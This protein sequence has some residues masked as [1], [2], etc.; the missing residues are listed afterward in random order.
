MSELTVSAGWLYTKATRLRSNEDVNLFPPGERVV[1]IRDTARNI[2]GLVSLPHFG[3]PSSRPVPFFD[4]IAE[5]RSDSNAVYHGLYLQGTKHYS[6]GLQ[7]F[8]NYTLSKLIDRGSAPGNQI[9]CCT[10][11]NPYRPGDERGLGR[12]D[13]RHRFNLAGV[14][15]AP[16]GLRFNAIVKAGS[17]RP[18]TPTVTGDSG[19]DLNGN[20]IRGG[21]RAPFFGPFSVIGPGYATV[22]LAAHKT[23]SFEGRR[24]EFG[25]ETFN[26]FNRANYLRP[27]TEYYTLTNVQNGI[28]RL[29][30]PLPT[31]AQPFDA[32]RSREVQFVLRFGF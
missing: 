19:G 4:Q 1:E 15:E 30:G 11:E 24:I 28:S 20:A 17:G 16:A 3:G 21:D 18:L 32:M 14:W 7:L 8:A 5:F 13:Q 27:A 29:E 23:F 9:Q 25:I 6:H 31:F 12:R 2:F 10:S 26:L 22:D